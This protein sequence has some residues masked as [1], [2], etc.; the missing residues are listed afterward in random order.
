ME[1]V[2]GFCGHSDAPEYVRQE[3]LDTIVS[4]IRAEQAQVF[5]VGNHDGFDRMALSVLEEVQVS[6]PDIR[7]YMVLAYLPQK[8]DGIPSDIPTIFPEGLETVPKRAAIPR[9]N[10]WIVDHASIMVAYVTRSFGGAAQT[11]TYA[12]RK[13]V[14]IIRLGASENGTRKHDAYQ[15]AQ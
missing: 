12:K 15:M 13:K 5:Y 9:R 6:F 7:I 3:L 14:E 2:C 10:Q 1:K 8:K 4:L 11:L